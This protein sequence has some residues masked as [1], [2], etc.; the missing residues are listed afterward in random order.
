MTPGHG[1][2]SHTALRRHE[3]GA[4]RRRRRAGWTTRWRHDDGLRATAHLALLFAIAWVTIGLIA[5]T[6]MAG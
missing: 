1:T 3:T 6:S 2:A 5:W 4:P